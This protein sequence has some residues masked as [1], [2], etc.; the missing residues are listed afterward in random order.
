MVNI[1]KG[2]DAIFH[3]D[4]YDVVLVGTSVY[5][6]LSN[7]FQAKMAFKYPQLE[8]ANNATN[9]GDLRNL[10]KRLTISDSKPIL[11][12][13]YIA[14]YP[15]SKR[16]FVDYD[17]LD[18]ATATADKEFAGMKVMTTMLGCSPFDGNGDRRKV[19]NILKRNCKNIDLDIYDYEQINKR[20][21]VKLQL[22]RIKSIK[23][24]D[25][26]KFEKLWSMKEQ[27][28]SKLFLKYQK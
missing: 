26:E 6:M 7:G 11:S 10:G 16:V 19:L 4:E 8:K 18:N 5:N 21:E 27:I 15:S 14:R 13:L 25:P 12:L 24:K 23:K 9:Y 1:I 22:N 20:Q 17:A 28:L 3:T 2:T